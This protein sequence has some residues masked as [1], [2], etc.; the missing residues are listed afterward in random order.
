MKV[1]ISGQITGLDIDEAKAYFKQAENFLE[2][3]G[4]ETVN[5]F[6]VLPYHPD[7]TWEEYMIADIRELF[8]CDAIYML[9][10]WEKSKGAKIEKAIAEGMGL[11]IMYN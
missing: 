7:T 3:L 6:D 11:I 8:K 4:H 1:Y 5:P 9:H 2:S 10:N